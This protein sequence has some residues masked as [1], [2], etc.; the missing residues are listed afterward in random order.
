MVIRWFGKC[1]PSPIY[2][3]SNQA[4]TPDG[5]DCLYCTE[6]IALGDD[7]FI[8]GGGSIFHR[9]CF[10]RMIIGSV[11]H[12]EQKCGCFGGEEQDHV[13]LGMTLR[14]EAEAALAHRERQ[15]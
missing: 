4:Q 7:G 13:A 2:G 10:L 15:W 3:I 11:L 6:E 5:Q 1:Y 14:Q 9:A 12:Q 8:D